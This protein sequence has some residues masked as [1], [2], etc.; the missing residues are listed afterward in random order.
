VCAAWEDAT[1]PATAAGI[2]TTFTRS[3]LVLSRHG[4]ALTPML[5]LFRLG[6]GGRFGS[7]RQW[8][9]WISLVDEVGAIRFLVE[10]DD[11]SGPVNLTAPDPVTNRDFAAALGRA[12][13]RPALLPIPRFGPRL[14]RGEM[15]DELIFASLRVEPGVLKAAGFRFAHPEL[16]GALAA[17]LGEAPA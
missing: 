16:D 4:G 5:Q 10:R 2:R 7:G 8:M 3:G 15:V 17:T 14:V 11:I 13:H 1:G 9:S 12:L 6:L